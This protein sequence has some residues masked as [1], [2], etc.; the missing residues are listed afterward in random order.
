MYQPQKTESIPTIQGAFLLQRRVYGDG[1]GQF[2]ELLSTGGVRPPRGGAILFGSGQTNFS[3]S[4]TGAVRGMHWQHGQGKL[5]TV[6]SGKVAD[7]MLDVRRGSPTFGKTHVQLLDT[8]TRDDTTALSIY[9]PPGVAHGVMA[10]CPT[11]LVYH[12]TQSWQPHNEGGVRFN[13]PELDLPWPKEC[14]LRI[15]SKK[16]SELPLWS[17]WRLNPSKLPQYPRTEA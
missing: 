17:Y 9:V 6:L 13:D 5:L 11:T 10:L 8:P 7:I 2:S 12:T 1:R 4:I 15:V 14:G 16:D 3:Y